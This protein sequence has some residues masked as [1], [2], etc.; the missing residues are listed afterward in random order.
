[1]KNFAYELN[2][3]HRIRNVN[4]RSNKV[5]TTISTTVKTNIISSCH[6]IYLD[7]NLPH[8]HSVLIDSSKRRSADGDTKLSVCGISFTGCKL[9]S[10]TV[11]QIIDP[12][13]QRILENTADCNKRDQKTVRN[14][15]S[16]IP[17]QNYGNTCKFESELTSSRTPKVG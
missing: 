14:Q 3:Y 2:S 16:C 7:V 17:P 10:V 15:K 1:M 13:D 6:W 11:R 5:R 8:Y 12:F 4:Y 9:S